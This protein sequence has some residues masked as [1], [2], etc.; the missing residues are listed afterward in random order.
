MKHYLL[1]AYIVMI[2]L[3]LSAC[4]GG[5]K[6]SSVATPLDTLSLKYAEN[7]KI[8][9]GKDYTVVQLRNPWDTTL[10][11]HTYVLVDKK[12]PLP[13]QLPQGTV[14]RTPLSKSLIYTAVHCSLLESLEA[15]PSIAAVCDA[16]YIKTE[17]VVRGCQEG[18]IVNAG[19]SMNPDIEKIIDLHPDAILLCPFENAGGYGRIEKLDIPLIECAD[20]METSALGCAEWMRF[21]GR[22]FGKAAM[23][24]SLFQV[25]EKNYNELKALAATDSVKPS[26]VCD[27]KSG[28]AWY[29]SGGKS[30]TG[31]MYTD[32]GANYVFS[33]YPQSGGI[34]L[35][36]ETVADLGQ[37]ADFWLIKYNQK[38]DK[39]LKE[40]KQDFAPYAKFKAYQNKKVYGCNANRIR[41]FEDSPFHP[42]LILKDL[43]K[44]FHPHLLPDYELK[45]FTPL[46]D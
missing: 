35:S 23:A 3:L 31:K 29:V 9:E 42:D 25:V 5:S 28:S 39:T 6:H 14:V 36:F 17:S 2:S 46:A 7:L 4:G 18:S 40:L 20:Y 38:T 12:Q 43:V 33:H 24:D 44:V 22:L 32:A 37:S 13:E 26:L 30:T 15:T 11:L 34:P 21:Y 27:L 41:F 19:N 8:A 16:E 45:Y 1:S 10:C